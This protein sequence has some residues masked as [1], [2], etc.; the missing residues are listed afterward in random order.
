MIFCQCDVARAYVTERMSQRVCH[1]SLTAGSD[2]ES[3]F[4]LLTPEA[5]GSAETLRSAPAQP[6]APS[7]F[8]SR[9][10]YRDATD[11]LIFKSVHRIAPCYMHFLFSKL[12]FDPIR[13]WISD[14]H[15]TKKSPHIHR[16]WL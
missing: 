14:T 13:T 8:L 4:S 9:A 2:S 12:I 1:V 15:H 10:L 11:K 16:S 6:I 5:A 7:S 3:E